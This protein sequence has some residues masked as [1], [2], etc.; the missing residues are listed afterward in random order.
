M[1]HQKQQFTLSSKVRKQIEKHTEEFLASGGT[2]TEIPYKMSGLPS[3]LDPN[4]PKY[5]CN[6]FNS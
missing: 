3:I 4:K 5:G 1:P 6:G 2:I